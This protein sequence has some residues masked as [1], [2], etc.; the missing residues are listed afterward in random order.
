MR[1]LDS[2]EVADRLERVMNSF[3]VAGPGVNDDVEA[4]ADAVVM[5]RHLSAKLAQYK[6]SE[7][8]K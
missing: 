8:E 2:D 7:M 1:I 5:I 3:F 4:M 6:K